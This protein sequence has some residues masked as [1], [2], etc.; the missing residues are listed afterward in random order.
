[1]RFLSAAAGGEGL[2]GGLSGDIWHICI[3]FCS[4]RE[5]GGGRLSGLLRSTHYNPKLSILRITFRF[6]RCS[7]RATGAMEFRGGAMF[8]SP[9]L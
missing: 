2:G 9:V 5:T 8:L 7:S 6:L 3:F 4:Q 1:M